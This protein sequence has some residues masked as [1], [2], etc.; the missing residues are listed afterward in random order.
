M[1]DF[2]QALEKASRDNMAIQK[3]ETD[4]AAAEGAKAAAAAATATATATA[5]EGAVGAEGGE[6]GEGSVRR[7]K[8]QREPQSSKIEDIFGNFSAF[9]QMDA[10]DIVSKV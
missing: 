8:P 9:Q 3:K 1:G 6:G 10:N 7:A 5:E 4:A 2:V